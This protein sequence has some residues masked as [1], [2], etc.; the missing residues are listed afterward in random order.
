[1]GSRW[2]AGDPDETYGPV[3]LADVV[4]ALRGLDPGFHSIVEVHSRYLDVTGGVASADLRYVSG[5]VTR[6]GA[7][8]C[9]HQGERGWRIDPAAL[10]KRWP[11]LPWSA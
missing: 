3:K 4:K 10:A 6:F 11:R 1:M 7:R 5:A 8:K 9:I 2:P